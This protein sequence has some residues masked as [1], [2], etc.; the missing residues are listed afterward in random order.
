MDEDTIQESFYSSSSSTA[1]L[2]KFTDTMKDH[3]TTTETKLVPS[4]SFLISPFAKNTDIEWTVEEDTENSSTEEEDSNVHTVELPFESYSV[5]TSAESDTYSTLKREDSRKRRSL[6]VPSLPPK[7]LCSIPMTRTNSPLPPLP[8]V[9]NFLTIM[10]GPTSPDSSYFSARS[11]SSSSSSTLS[12]LTLDD[13]TDSLSKAQ[14]EATPEDACTPPIPPPKDPISGSKNT[15]KH[16]LMDLQDHSITNMNNKQEKRRSSTCSNSLKRN[17]STE[18]RISTSDISNHHHPSSPPKSA[19]V[20]LPKK[21]PPIPPRTSSM[22]LQPPKLNLSTDVPPLPT[23]SLQRTSNYKR[24]ASAKTSTDENTWN[25]LLDNQRKSDFAK[26][27]KLARS[28]GAPSPSLKKIKK[29]DSGKL[30]KVTENGN[31]VLLF[32]MM[33]GKLQAIAGTA[34]KIFERLADE[35]AQDEEYVDI[36]LMNHAHFVP[37]IDLVNS[38]INRFH[39]EPSPGEYEYFLKWQFSIQSK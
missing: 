28:L 31:V 20:Y 18:M 21:R 6:A 14:I 30:L 15:D 37:S 38:L 33:D 32:E 27:T 39:L 36:Y 7:V 24:R 34:E 4:R 29:S 25:V 2:S 19:D 10:N 3:S 22:P 8:T 16:Q 26:R 13:V 1:S 9:E 23:D 35:T 12:S 5:T 17:S 11:T